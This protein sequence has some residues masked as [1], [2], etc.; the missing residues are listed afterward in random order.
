MDRHRF[1]PSS[2]ALDRRTLL[3]GTGLFGQSSSTLT[4]SLSVR[5]PDTFNEKLL[6]IQRVP[7]YLDHLQSNRFLPAST[8]QALQT[9]MVSVAAQLHPAPPPVLRSFNLQIRKMLPKVS[10]SP[11]DASKLNYL[12]G[13]VLRSEGAT[14][15]QVQNLSRDMISIAKADAASPNSVYL[16][17]NDYSIMVQGISI[18][19]RR[20]EEPGRSVLAR[21]SGV[22]AQ[23]DLGRTTEPQP[24]LVGNYRPNAKVDPGTRIQVI[25][26]QGNVLGSGPVILSGTYAGRYRFTL[27]TPLQPGTNWLRTRAVDAEGH[28][29]T[30]SPVFAIRLV[31]S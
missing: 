19:G 15:Q 26:L 21:G 9:D 18:V 12:F 17:T 22:R 25:D 24:T 27:D 31:G 13:V 30:P 29:S 3:S 14:P 2:E 10:L 16:A 23:T 4:G 6:R 7:Y 20:I 8:L 5:T 28:L 11:Q 1:V